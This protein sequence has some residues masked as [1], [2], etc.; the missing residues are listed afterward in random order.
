[1]LASAR[2]SDSGSYSCVAVSAVGE[3]RRD[4]VL[5]VHSESRAPEA[6]GCGLEAQDGGAGASPGDG[7]ARSVLRLRLP[8]C[9]GPSDPPEPC[10]KL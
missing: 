2:V 7:C 8:S 9:R 5:R 4:V 10:L 6:A 1:M 3:D